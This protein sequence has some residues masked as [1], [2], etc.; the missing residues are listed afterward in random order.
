M[1]TTHQIATTYLHLDSGLPIV[2]A[3]GL[4]YPEIKE[5]R[6]LSTQF[7]LGDDIL[8][9]PVLKKNVRTVDCFVPEDGWIL[10]WDRK[11]YTKG[12]HTIPS[13]IGEPCILSKPQTEA[14]ELLHRFVTAEKTVDRT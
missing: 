9:A 7:F 3:I 4:V 8:V 11:E 13:P 14:H 1:F 6:N 2:R 10:C 12:W 5:Q